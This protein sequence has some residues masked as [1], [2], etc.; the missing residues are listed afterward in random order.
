MVIYKVDST[1]NTAAVDIS[2]CLKAAN[3][4]AF[5]CTATFPNVND[6][7]ISCFNPRKDRF[8]SRFWVRKL[9]A[10]RIVTN[11]PIVEVIRLGQIRIKKC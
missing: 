3:I 6:R 10:A 2:H 4:Y 11:N 9:R 8:T 7:G 5:T 1:G